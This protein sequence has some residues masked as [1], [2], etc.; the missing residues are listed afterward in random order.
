MPQ[1]AGRPLR[2]VPRHRQPGPFLVK[3]QEEHWTSQDVTLALSGSYHSKFSSCLR[4]DRT[5]FQHC[6]LVSR[7]W[8]M[9]APY[10]CRKLF[11]P[12]CHDC[13]ES[14]HIKYPEDRCRCSS[15]DPDPLKNL[16]AY[17]QQPLR[18]SRGLR[19]LNI[20][21]QRI[22]RP[23]YGDNRTTVIPEV[24]KLFEP[25]ALFSWRS[26]LDSQT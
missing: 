7:S 21:L 3:D 4:V 22:F 17:L 25:S 1:T 13:W 12:P 18:A 10:L 2:A 9:A 5:S 23:K 24:V 19:E 20:S 15:Y 14:E 16:L 26:W 8:A 6:S 11:W